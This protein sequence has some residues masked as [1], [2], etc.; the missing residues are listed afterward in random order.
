MHW[1]GVTESLHT[2]EVGHYTKLEEEKDD[3]TQCWV[4]VGL[5]HVCSV[6]VQC[7]SISLHIVYRFPLTQ[8]RKRILS[9]NADEITYTNCNLWLFAAKPRQVTRRNRRWRDHCEFLG[10]RMISHLIAGPQVKK[11][12]FLSDWQLQYIMFWLY[13]RMR[14]RICWLTSAEGRVHEPRSW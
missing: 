14:T 7:F 2:V 10:A 6:P 13:G 9:F 5:S 8:S 11:F 4:H 12:S 3:P 1:L